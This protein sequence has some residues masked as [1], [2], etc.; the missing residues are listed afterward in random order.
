MKTYRI[1]AVV[2]FVTMLATT[3]PGFAYESTYIVQ[4]RERIIS[5]FK[6][7]RDVQAKA[8][9]DSK[10]LV[11]E[12]ETLN[13]LLVK[14]DIDS[15]KKRIKDQYWSKKGQLIEVTVIRVVKGLEYVQSINE[16]L[17]HLHEEFQ[18]EEREDGLEMNDK[19]I[20]LVKETLIG[21]DQGLSMMESLDPE[22]PQ[23]SML[24]RT[25]I[26]MDT[27]YRERFR[28]K[29]LESL[30]KIRSYMQDVKTYLGS[31]KGYLGSLIRS[32]K[33]T[34]QNRITGEITEWINKDINISN[35]VERFE[36]LRKMDEKMMGSIEE[37]KANPPIKKPI[38]TW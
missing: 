38:G 5:D 29:D 28:G 20:E 37:I 4:L 35:M 33:I 34:T 15:E 27:T 6:K 19:D 31:C 3:P 16:N 12:L 24:V 23:Y 13:V 18:R 9:K 11:S 21:F 7:L 2:V 14:A 26:T 32:T 1:V 8:D 25:L 30:Q 36:K 22:N 10:R 17:K